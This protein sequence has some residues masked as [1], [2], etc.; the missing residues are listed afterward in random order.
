[1]EVVKDEGEMLEVKE[2]GKTYSFKVAN[3]GW[4]EPEKIAEKFIVIEKDERTPT[5]SRII[6]QFAEID[7]E[8]MRK[9]IQE[10]KLD[11]VETPRTPDALKAIPPEVKDL[12]VKK[13]APNF[14]KEK[15]RL[16]NLAQS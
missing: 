13:A 8:I 3:L 2:D 14:N 1:M 4:Y 10:F 15:A 5:V 7:L 12:L 11:G 9:G 6:T 16:K